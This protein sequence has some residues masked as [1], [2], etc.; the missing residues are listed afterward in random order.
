MPAWSASALATP[1]RTARTWFVSLPD[2]AARLL[3]VGTPTAARGTRI[4]ATMPRRRGRRSPPGSRSSSTPLRSVPRA[5]APPRSP[6]AYYACGCSA[7]T[8]SVPARSPP[9]APASA[10]AG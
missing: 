9:V 1:T 8:P 5:P 3:S 2:P 7:P 6:P 4:S 10:L